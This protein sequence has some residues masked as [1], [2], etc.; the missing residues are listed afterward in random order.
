MRQQCI[1]T[2]QSN[3][4]FEVSLCEISVMDSVMQPNL[5]APPWAVTGIQMLTSKP[6]MPTIN[7]NLLAN[8]MGFSLFSMQ[9]R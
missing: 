5:V 7:G 4:M 8:I 9:T 6:S 2:Q 3:A 1:D